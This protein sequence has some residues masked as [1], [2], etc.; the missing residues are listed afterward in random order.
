MLLLLVSLLLLTSLVMLLRI[1][2]LLLLTLL[3]TILLLPVA[4]LVIVSAVSGIPAAAVGLTS[5]G[6]LLREFETCIPKILI[7]RPRFQIPNSHSRTIFFNSMWD[8]NT[9]QWGRRLECR[10]CIHRC[11]KTL[12]LCHYLQMSWSGRKSRSTLCFVSPPIKET[13][14][15]DFL[16]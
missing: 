2:F 15:R 11:K 12:L 8:H 1:M 4:F 16:L 10:R 7:A 3:W 9:Y 14:P 5:A 13:V 6:A